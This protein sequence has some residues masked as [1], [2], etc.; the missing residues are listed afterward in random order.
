MKISAKEAAEQVGMSKAGIVKAIRT[1]KI[2]GEKNVHGEW[3]V[4]TSE[5]FRVY[6]PV[7][8]NADPKPIV[9]SESVVTQTEHLQTQLA[10]QRE[11]IEKQEK[12]IEDLKA[13]LVAKN[14]LLLTDK[15]HQTRSWW[16]R[17]IGQ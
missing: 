8:T 5:L 15:Q 16:Q 1:G 11:I 17:L 7:P 10:L 3:E 6:Q 12:H 14:Q 4:D 2:T 13:E 9:S